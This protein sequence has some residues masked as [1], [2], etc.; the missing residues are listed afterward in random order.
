MKELKNNVNTLLWLMVTLSVMVVF[1]TLSLSSCNSSVQNGNTP[2]PGPITVKITVIA[3]KEGGSIKVNGKVLKET[4]DFNPKVGDTITFEA[5]HSDGYK[6][7]EWIPKKLGNKE[8]FELTVTKDMKDLSVSVEFEKDTSTMT[9]LEFLEYKI[10]FDKES[11]VVYGKDVS[12]EQLRIEAENK[13]NGKEYAIYTADSLGFGKDGSGKICYHGY[14][15][16]KDSIVSMTI[17]EELNNKNKNDNGNGLKDLGI[18]ED[19][20]SIYDGLEKRWMAVHKGTLGNSL[21]YYNANDAPDGIA[22]SLISTIGGSYDFGLGSDKEDYKLY[23]WA[24]SASKYSYYMDLRI[25]FVNEGNPNKGYSVHF[26][27]VNDKKEYEPYVLHNA[28]DSKYTEYPPGAEPKYTEST[29]EGMRMFRLSSLL[30]TSLEN[31]RKNDSET[32][33]YSEEQ[34]AKTLLKKVKDKNYDI[35]IVI[36]YVSNDLEKEQ[37]N[38]FV[39]ALGTYWCNALKFGDPFWETLETKKP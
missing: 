23:M 22:R 14:N 34:L 6:F 17:D 27:H 13:A 36:G 2:N 29:E 28:G 18:K 37:F 16:Y 15:S 32:W 31:L 10:G 5:V 26:C 39:T 20:K 33:K 24:N 35:Y 30:K 4:K 11:E 25:A 19:F 12:R 9:E 7:K 3:P 21:Y 1:L 8:T 38:S